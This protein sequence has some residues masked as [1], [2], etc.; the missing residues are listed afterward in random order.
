MFCFAMINV[1]RA[2]FVTETARVAST[3]DE[4]RL[5][6][7]EGEREDTATKLK[8]VFD[9]LDD[10]GNGKLTWSEF[11]ALLDDEVLLKY[12]SALEIDV[13]DA[14]KLFYILDD[15]DNTISTEEFC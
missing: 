5:M 9:E 13:K 7:K 4:V 1:I 3:D 14:L 2:V 10:D 6:R 8:D 11:T 12:L 15:G